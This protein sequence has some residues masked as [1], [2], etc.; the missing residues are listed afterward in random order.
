[1]ECIDCIEVAA[2]LHLYL[3]RELST[4]EVSQVQQH[5]AS[6]PECECRFHMDVSIKRLIHERCAIQRAPERLRE[7]V[8]QL[9]RQAKSGTIVSVTA[10]EVELKADIEDYE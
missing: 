3:D 6:C 1:M 7:A 5:L 4:E 9:A 8:L 10:F 2:R